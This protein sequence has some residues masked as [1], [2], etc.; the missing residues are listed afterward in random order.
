M[1]AERGVL[2]VLIA[3]SDPGQVQ[4]VAEIVQGLGHMVVAREITVE[5]VAA[6]T[7]EEHPDVA[8]VALGDSG[9]HALRLIDEIVRQAECPVI[10]LLLDV[11]DPA[12][13]NEAARRGIFGY[14]GPGDLDDLP[15][16][17]EI[18][19]SRFAEY[20]RLEGAFGRRAITE[21]AKGILMERHNIDA[22]AAFTMLRNHARSTNQRV[23]DVA[24]AV[25][26]SHR[27]LTA[28][29]D[30]ADPDHPPG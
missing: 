15:S 14:V 9:A 4:R 30:E 6:V 19:L 13:V 28:A 23:V 17:I 12:F 20:H 8:L 7:G 21:Q 2:R 26:T 3:D 24:V 29:P 10:A 18:V 1:V 27:L 25:T 16:A 11:R 5:T 22:Q